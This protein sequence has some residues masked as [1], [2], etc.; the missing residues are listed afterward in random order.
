MGFDVGL[1]P[2]LGPCIYAGN[3]TCAGTVGMATAATIN[4]S[5]ERLRSEA[6]DRGA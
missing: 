1:F 5:E 3:E 6:K 4:E 2:L